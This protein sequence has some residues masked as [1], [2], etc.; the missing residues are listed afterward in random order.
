[1]NMQHDKGSNPRA[2]SLADDLTSE[3]QDCFE[4]L[5]AAQ[6]PNI[7]IFSIRQHV[8]SRVT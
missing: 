5:L 1:M 6:V 2:R 7:K 8:F 3:M 4:I